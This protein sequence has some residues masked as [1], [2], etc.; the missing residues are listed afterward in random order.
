MAK[1]LQADSAQAMTRIDAIREII[2]RLSTT[3][4]SIFGAAD[5][6]L[7]LALTHHRFEA[8]ARNGVIAF[9]FDSEPEISVN[10]E[11]DLFR[12]V[13]ARI[14]KIISEQFNCEFQPYGFEGDFT[15]SRPDSSSAKLHIE[16]A[17]TPGKKWFKSTRVE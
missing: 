12:V 11:R 8:H 15:F 5:I 4:G 7:D 9:T 16:L 1:R 3:D 6:T 17:N 10:T 13:L 2:E 14:A